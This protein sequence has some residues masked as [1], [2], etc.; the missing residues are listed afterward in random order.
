MIQC[1]D[2]AVQIVSRT[3]KATNLISAQ[4]RDQFSGKRKRV[5]RELAGEISIAMRVKR[6]AKTR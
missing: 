1:G 3:G 6:K 4:M 2:H 5:A